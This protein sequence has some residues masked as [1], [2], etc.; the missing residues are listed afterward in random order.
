MNNLFYNTSSLIKF[1][2][3]KEKLKTPIYIITMAMFL[4]FI[5][6]VFQN[7]LD[8]SDDMTIIVETMKNPA[9]IST[10]GPVF[11]EDSYTV[12]S[13]Y[14]NYMT[15]FIGL[16]HG[17]WNILFISSHTRKDEELGRLELINSFPV[18][19][20]SNLTSTLIVSFLI[21]LLLSLIT[22]IGFYFISSGEME[23]KGIII[24]GLSLGGF[25]F[26]F[27][28]ITAFFSQITTTSRGTNTLSFLTLVVVYLLRAIGDVSVEVLSLISP[29]GLITRTENF[30]NDYFWPLGVL[31][32]E[33]ILIA[34]AS[35]YFSYNRDLGGGLIKERKGRIE[36]S[37]ILSG[38]Y[39]FTFRL[40]RSQIFIWIVVIMVFSGMYGA[41]FGD[42]ENYLKSSE[43]IRNM[44]VIDSD[45]SL[46]DQ[47]ISMLMLVMSMISAVPVLIFINRIISEEKNSYSEIILTKPVSK[48]NYLGSFYIISVFSAVVFQLIIAGTFYGIG[49]N[50]LEDIPSLQTFI[51]SA[52]NY[53]PPILITLGISV[54]LIGLIPKF[55]WL[56]Y[57]YLGYTFVVVYLGRLLDFPEILEKITPF[58]YVSNYPLEEIDKRAL[59]IQLG[60]F[61]IMSIIGFVAYRNRD[62]E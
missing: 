37:K 40:L 18:G 54:L 12:G 11:V 3:K 25:G 51:I 13:I 48:I 56:S 47:F 55:H 60:I 43:L 9:M 2:L 27:S 39:T 6:P 16:I 49:K 45:H 14:A 61:V 8:T 24:F 62:V 29:L 21:N 1:I 59:I 36:G 58:G 46:T 28:L 34:V 23:I 38:I 42:L 4:V 53:I 44:L 5:V 35:Y 30:V 17:A 19:R 33:I 50:Y 57:V 52:I 22:G 20:L 31:L 7:I 15:V 32:V 26:L 41:V 10:V